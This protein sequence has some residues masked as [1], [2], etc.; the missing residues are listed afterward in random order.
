MSTLRTA[1][2]LAG[3]TALFLGVGYALAGAGG[4]MVA[5]VLACA[6]NAYAY[7]NADRVVLRMHGAR[8]VDAKSAPG[9]HGIVSQFALNA[10]LPMV[11]VYV[12][13]SAQPNAFATGRNPKHAAVATTT[14][15]L[16]R[17]SHEEMAGVMA[18]ELAHV[19]SRD[20]LIMTMTATI[21]GAL[22]MLAGFALF[23]GRAGRNNPLGI[24]G[25]IALAI[26]APIAAMLVQMA[27]SRARE[28]EADKGGA[29]ICGRPL[30]LASALEKL[31]RGASRIDNPAAEANPATAHL[32]IV[33][34]LHARLG[35][36]LFSSH[37]R[38]A[39]RVRRLREMAGV[40]GPWG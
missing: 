17:L 3:L 9:L 27:L 38:T 20:T 14:G 33:N 34:P 15:L 30:W 36:R 39:E 13:D 2:L 5:L 18:H 19:R 8:E 40:A 16:E 29:E 10:G 25:V 23:F 22:S 12:I 26:L 24:V 4:K 1:I 28:F 37:P 7:W 21:A 31:E 11:R 35:N 6:T 32:F